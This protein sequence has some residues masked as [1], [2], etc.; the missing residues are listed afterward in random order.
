MFVFGFL[1]WWLGEEIHPR[2]H[3]ASALEETQ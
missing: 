1:L 3:P 2:L